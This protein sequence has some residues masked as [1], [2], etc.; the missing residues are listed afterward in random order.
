MLTQ[1]FLE[2]IKDTKQKSRGPFFLKYFGSK[3]SYLFV[4]QFHMSVTV[5][6]LRRV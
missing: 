1:E 4:A 5:S 2:D 6:G 3:L